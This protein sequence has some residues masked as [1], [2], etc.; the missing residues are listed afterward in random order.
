MKGQPNLGHIACCQL[1]FS[2]PSM[3][4]QTSIFDLQ[5]LP[6]LQPF[7]VCYGV[8]IRLLEQLLQQEQDQG[9]QTP[10]PLQGYTYSIEW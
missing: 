9:F 10:P 5:K 2:V 4:P 6:V 1:A 3:P 8:D 7:P